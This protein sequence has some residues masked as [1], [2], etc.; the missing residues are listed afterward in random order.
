MLFS[1]KQSYLT[2]ITKSL[3]FVAAITLASCSGGESGTSGNQWSINEDSTYMEEVLPDTMEGKEVT[4]ECAKLSYDLD[5]II[6]KLENVKSPSMLIRVREEYP[7]LM[8]NIAKEAGLLSTEES[9]AIAD[10][11]ERINEL[12]R[13][14]CRAYE[15]EAAS[16]IQNLNRCAKELEQ[17]HDSA[18]MAQFMSYRFATVSNLKSAHLC[19]DQRSPRIGEIRQ[20]AHKLEGMV[21]SKKQRFSK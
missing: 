16:V 1:T 7:V 3:T 8:G 5:A 14:V 6:L 12:Y 15:V 18:S 19:V 20:L 11:V 9:A 10:K 17:V 2:L 13:H 4:H 21:Q